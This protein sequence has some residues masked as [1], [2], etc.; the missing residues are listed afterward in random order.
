[1]TCRFDDSDGNKVWD[2][3]VIRAPIT[4][5]EPGWYDL[6]GELRDQSAALLG[7][8]FLTSKQ[9]D[10]GERSLEFRIPR[11]LI[12]RSIQT[13]GVVLLNLT[14]T[15][16]ENGLTFHCDAASNIVL[17]LGPKMRIRR[18][19]EP[20]N[21]CLVSWSPAGPYV[22]ERDSSPEFK[23]PAIL[24]L[25]EG[26]TE[27]SFIPSGSAGFF[28]LFWKTEGTAGTNGYSVRVGTR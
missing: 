20:Q 6:S 24:P 22:L 1:L 16:W 11:A 14:L 8:L 3:L 5:G 18:V 2:A 25:D 7:N 23:T 4:I 9:L 15:K 10:A 13:E 27:F 28:R 17:R 21:G 12:P 19:Q 26:A